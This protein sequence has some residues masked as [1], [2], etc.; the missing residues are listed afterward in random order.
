M[1]TK[2]IVGLVM[3]LLIVGC[4]REPSIDPYITF[5]GATVCKGAG[6]KSATDHPSDQDCLQYKWAE[7]DSLIIKHVNANFNCCPQGF[8]TEVKVSGDT[9]IISEYENEALCDCNCLYD[10]DYYVV[11]I[12]KTTW[13]IRIEEP[14]IQQ[15]EQEKI[16][17]KAELRKFPESEFCVTR[18]GYPWGT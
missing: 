16:L 18:T 8:R 14:Y 1:Q 10:L 9:I 11:G 4:D 7:G 13:W 5:A 12:T 6:L 3:L 2:Q 17:F 15:Q